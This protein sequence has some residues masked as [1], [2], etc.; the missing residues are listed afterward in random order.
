MSQ[1]HQFQFNPFE[2][3]VQPKRLSELLSDFIAQYIGALE[4]GVCHEHQ[5]GIAVQ[6]KAGENMFFAVNRNASIE[7]NPRALVPAHMSDLVAH[8][9]FTC[10][11]GSYRF[12]TDTN[13]GATAASDMTISNPIIIRLIPESGPSQL[14]LMPLHDPQPEQE[15]DGIFQAIRAVESSLTRVPSASN[16]RTRYHH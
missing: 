11:P 10:E 6:T 7:R 9:I 14:W 8:A 4:A 15:D 12:T 3:Y 13:N 5:C 1:H 16:G 2:I